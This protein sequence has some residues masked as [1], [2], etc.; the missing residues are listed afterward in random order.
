MGAMRACGNPSA[1]AHPSPANVAQ[2]GDLATVFENIRPRAKAAGMD[3]TRDAMYNFFVAEVKRNLHI[4]LSFSPVGDAFRERLRKFPSL[5]NCTTIDW[6]MQWPRDALHSV[7]SNFLAN[8]PG[9]DD[10]VQKALPD[11]CVLFHE[12]VYQLSAR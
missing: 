10:A 11:L 1:A 5:V 12:S 2:A 6:F 3:G 9:V 4:V 7:A 8:L